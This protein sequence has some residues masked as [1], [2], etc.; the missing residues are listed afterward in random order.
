MG[1]RGGFKKECVGTAQSKNDKGRW[2][3][4]MREGAGYLPVEYFGKMDSR[5]RA[6]SF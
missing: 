1:G 4:R 5:L 6:A 2:G 3:G